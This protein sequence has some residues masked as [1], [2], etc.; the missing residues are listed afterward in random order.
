MGSPGTRV[1]LHGPQGF[2]SLTLCHHGTVRLAPHGR[3]SNGTTVGLVGTASHRRTAP[4]STPVEP[5]QL[6]ADLQSRRRPAILRRSS[7]PGEPRHARFD[8]ESQT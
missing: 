8:I 3:P 2:E 5:R 7:A 4:P 6:L 1:G